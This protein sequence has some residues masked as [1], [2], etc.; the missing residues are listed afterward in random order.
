MNEQAIVFAYLLLDKDNKLC[1]R[2]H[3]KEG[4]NLSDILLTKEIIYKIVKNISYSIPL[5]Y[6]KDM[7]ICIYVENNELKYMASPTYNLI[8]R[9]I[10]NESIQAL[11]VDKIRTVKWTV[12]HLYEFVNSTLEFFKK[13]SI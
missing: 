1:I 8:N 3:Y 13:V 4:F 5:Y 10:D 6:N 12:M 7:F 9:I 2:R 11:Y